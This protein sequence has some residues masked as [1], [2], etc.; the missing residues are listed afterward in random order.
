M[1]A[2]GEV[3]AE[4]HRP[5]P[6]LRSNND[7]SNGGSVSPE[8]MSPASQRKVSLILHHYQSIIIYLLEDCQSYKMIY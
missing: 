1:R 4:N 7:L 8:Q 2:Q 5:S 6:T 3:M